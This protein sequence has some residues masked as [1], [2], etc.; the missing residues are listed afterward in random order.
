MHLK[1]VARLYKKH[2]KIILSAFLGQ[3]A[4]D[5]PFHNKARFA[6]ALLSQEEMSFLQAQAQGRSASVFLPLSFVQPACILMCTSPRLRPYPL[7]PHQ[8]PIA[9]EQQ[10]FHNILC[11]GIFCN[12][13][14]LACIIQEDGLIVS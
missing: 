5:T 9:Q 4:T 3:S 2:K 6:R 14:L 13:C 8:A 10:F 7:L 11:R 1:E 12:L